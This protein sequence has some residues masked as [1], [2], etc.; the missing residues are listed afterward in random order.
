M[1][2]MKED[3]IFVRRPIKCYGCGR[4]KTLR[5]LRIVFC[6]RHCAIV[7]CVRTFAFAK[8]TILGMGITDNEEMDFF[9]TSGSCLS[10]SVC[11]KGLLLTFL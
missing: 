4:K 3:V 10:L 1:T 11:N 9:L 8:N 2:S 5:M 6:A 7:H